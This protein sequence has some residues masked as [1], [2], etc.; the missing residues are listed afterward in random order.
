VDK[1]RALD[2]R[3]NGRVT[4]ITANS[5]EIEKAVLDADLVIGAVLIPGAAAPKL[6]S[7]DLVARMKPGSVLGVSV[8]FGGTGSRSR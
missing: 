4:T 6:V 7:N 2:R 3:Y 8:T 5:F 1:L